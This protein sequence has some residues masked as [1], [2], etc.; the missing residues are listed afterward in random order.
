[1]F[2]SPETTTGGNALKFYASQR[3]KVSGSEKTEGKNATTG[4]K[5]YVGKITKVSV[6]KNKVAPPFRDAEM[7]IEYGVGISRLGEILDIG[8]K[9]WV[10]KKAGAFYS[11]GETRLGQGRDNSK[12]FLAENPELAEKIHS[13]IR[14]AILNQSSSAKQTSEDF[15]S[16]DED[17]I[18]E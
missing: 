7:E 10:V 12:K 17:D 1:M 2:G 13:E 5:E 4:E 14:S 15:E 3:L 8:D 18:E 9:T 11:Y 16:N 6:V